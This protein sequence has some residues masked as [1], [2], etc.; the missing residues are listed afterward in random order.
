[1]ALVITRYRM[2]DVKIILFQVNKFVIT[3]MD[4]I[5]EFQH[6][7]ENIFKVFKFNVNFTIKNY[8]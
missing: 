4:C 6:K 8:N 5:D 2:R 3:L 7:T 1:M